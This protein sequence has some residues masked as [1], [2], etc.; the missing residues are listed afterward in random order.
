MPVSKR[1]APSGTK[2]PP[3][4]KRETVKGQSGTPILSSRRQSQA[5]PPKARRK[6]GVT[7][8]EKER[9]KDYEE[10]SDEEA[11]EDDFPLDLGEDN[12]EAKDGMDVDGQSSSAPIKDPNGKRSPLYLIG[13]LWISPKK[14]LV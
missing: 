13:L 6:L 1:S 5:V 8:S 7:A 11:G 12:D 9:T 2:G 4:K 10:S 14:L 3:Q